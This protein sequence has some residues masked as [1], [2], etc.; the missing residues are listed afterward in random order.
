M[1]YSIDLRKKVLRYLENGGSKKDAVNIFGICERT[2]WHWIR[3]QKEGNLYPKVREVK[4]RKINN[5]KL[6]QYIKDNPD[7]YLKEIASAFKVTPTAIFYACKRLR[8]T[9]KKRRPYI[10]K[11]IKKKEKNI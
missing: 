9:L 5:K 8:I 6:I 4:P 3:K 7:S 11:V 1:Y 2:I 10:E